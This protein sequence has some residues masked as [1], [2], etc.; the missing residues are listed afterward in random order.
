MVPTS[1]LT[2]EEIVATGVSTFTFQVEV[3]SAD[4]S[5]DFAPAFCE[6]LDRY[7]EQCPTPLTS[8]L[9]NLQS[10]VKAT[11]SVEHKDIM[12]PNALDKHFQAIQGFDDGLRDTPFAVST[13]LAE[14]FSPSLLPS[15]R[16]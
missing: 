11:D 12:T 8:T 6:L 13:Q 7:V 1:S 15:P 16:T 3:H 9:Q 4:L 5:S 2:C 14:I 10:M